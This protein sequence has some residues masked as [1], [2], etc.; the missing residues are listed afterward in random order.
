MPFTF[1]SLSVSQYEQ[2]LTLMSMVIV[3]FAAWFLVMMLLRVGRIREVTGP[4]VAALAYVL[5]TLLVF[6]AVAL[7]LLFDWPR[8]V[9]FVIVFFK[10]VSVIG[11]A[12]W[13]RAGM[14]HGSK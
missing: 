6:T 10:M 1:A 8:E 5:G 14:A 11:V 7:R 12:M 9:Y 4:D 13:A 3:V 2:G